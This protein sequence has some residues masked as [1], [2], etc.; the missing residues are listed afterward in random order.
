[1]AQ[2][3]GDLLFV[4][5]AARYQCAR[6]VGVEQG[7]IDGLSQGATSQTQCLP[8]LRAG[9]SLQ[10]TRA[11][12]LRASALYGARF[13]SL[14]ERFGTSASMRGNSSL[15]AERG[16]GGDIGG[17]VGGATKH[18][19]ASLE[20]SAFYRDTRDVIAYQ[21]VGLGYVRPFNLDRGRFYGVD[22]QAQLDAWALLRLKSNVSF[23]DARS[24]NESGQADNFIPYRSRFTASAE[25]ELH[26]KHLGAEVDEAGL[27]AAL[28]FRGARYADPAN[29]IQI[30]SQASL[31]L[32]ARVRFYGCVGLQFR[33]ENVTNASRFDTLGYPLPSRGYYLS[34]EAEF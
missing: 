26:R 25:V 17:R 7:Y 9:F 12:K 13:A 23:L 1:V 34:L 32:V 14:G 30:P 29:L 8:G 2:T 33:V 18:V 27:G 6:D 31:D 10:P 15:R 19:E 24:V 4:R 21:R 11:L 5:G 20:S 22:V 16:I 3:F 28:Y